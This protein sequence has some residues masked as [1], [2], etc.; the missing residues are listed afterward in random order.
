MYQLIIFD[1]DGTLMD[2]AQKIANCIKAAARELSIDEPSDTQAKNIIGLG[3][4]EAMAVLFPKLN[5]EQLIKLVEVYKYHYV[6]GDETE[7]NL[8]ESVNEGLQK[9][10]EAGALLA[11]ATGKSRRGLDRNFDE[12]D[13][14]KHFVTTRCGDE[15]RSKPHPLMLLEILDYTAIDPKN[16]IMIGDTTY[17]MDMAAN[18]KMHGLGVSYGVHTEQDLRQ[19]NPVEVLDSFTSVVDWLLDGRIEKA[20]N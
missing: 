8:F 14:K 1:W 16:S 12:I 20:Y 13:I 5:A 7:Q 11:V 10:N 4:D 19:S 18:A 3:L 9:L 15:T 6:N 2:S 17:D